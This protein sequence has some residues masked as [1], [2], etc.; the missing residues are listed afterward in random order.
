MDTLWRDEL[1]GIYIG[2]SALDGED[3]IALDPLIPG[4]WVAFQSATRACLDRIQAHPVGRDLLSLISKRCQ[5]IGVRAAGL[6]CKI[7]LGRGTLSARHPHTARGARYAIRQALDATHA[8]ET[9]QPNSFRE[10]R[11]LL[12]GARQ[13][14]VAGDGRAATVGYNPFVNYDVVLQALIGVPM[15]GFIALAHELVHGLHTLSGD[16]IRHEDDDTETLIE[17]ART[18]GAG[19]Y[20]ETRISENAIRLENGLPRRTYYLQPGDCRGF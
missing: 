7:Y 14:A 2:G 15:P 20:R 11:G 13:L 1:P 18:I 9:T 8:P 19:R 6:T 4:E 3:G 5:G 12:G 10:Q 17:E 16:C